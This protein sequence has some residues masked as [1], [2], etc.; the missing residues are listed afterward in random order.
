MTKAKAAAP[1]IAR[2]SHS[3]GT[4]VSASFQNRF[5][6]SLA[7]WRVEITIVSYAL[8]QSGHVALRRFSRRN[9]LAIYAATYV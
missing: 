3:M 7:Q 8:S 6:K 1:P 2:S 4:L 5:L 9:F